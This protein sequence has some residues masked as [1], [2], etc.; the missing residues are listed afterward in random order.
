[1]KQTKNKTLPNI[2]CLAA[3]KVVKQ[4]DEVSV[5]RVLGVP[6]FGPDYLGGKDLQGEYF[7]K[8]TDFAW[9]PGQRIPVVSKGLSYYDHAFHELFGG[10]PIGVAK[11]YAETEEGQWWDIEVAR[12][13]RYHDF[14]LQL[15]EKGVLG[16]SSQPVQT[17]VKINWDSGH[18]DR[19]HTVEISLT[20][21][22]ANPLAV[23]EI[24]KSFEFSPEM[25]AVLE[26]PRPNV[27]TIVVKTEVPEMF[28]D[29][30]EDEAEAE[31]E[32]EAEETPVENAETPAESEDLSDVIQSA[33]AGEDAEET[34]EEETPEEETPAEETP[35]PVDLANVE[36]MLTAIQTQVLAQTELIKTTAAT[37]EA[38][39]KEI[40]KMITQVKSGIQKFALEV[41]K[42]LKVKVREAAQEFNEMSE[43]ERDA[44]I[45]R[46]AAKDSN[47]QFTG[48][49]KSVPDNVPGR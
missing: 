21:T 7:D 22:P 16:A 11:F 5:I 41:A 40:V 45:E 13:F 23:A 46:A 35:A 38:R 30:T 39:D 27:K 33:F 17:S 12:S 37:Q 19:W 2:V 29:G 44:E 14:L 34:P 8:F 9:E 42:A 25:L 32:A 28:N 49:S 43:A 26:R 10:D 48:R 1:M 31:A 20:P 15:A 18:I 24:A 3:S 47:T 4:T 6:Y 36:K